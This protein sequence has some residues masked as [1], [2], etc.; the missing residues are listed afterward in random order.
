MMNDKAKILIVDDEPFN[1][2]Y[3]EQELEELG[4]ETVSA[5]D[6]QEALEQTVAENPDAILLDILMPELD[7]FQVLERLKA[8]EKW[9]NIPVIVISALGD[10]KSV[11]KGIEMGAEEYLPKPFDPVLLK[12]RISACL[13]KKRLH[14][15]ELG[16]L[17]QLEC[18]VQARTADLRVAYERLQ[19]LE[20]NKTDFIQV[21]AHELRTPL[22]VLRGCSEMLLVDRVIEASAH[23]HQLVTGI[24]S[25]AMRM[26]DVVDVMVDMARI[27]NRTLEFYPGLFI[28][29][30]L[31]ENVTHSFKGAMAD[32]KQTLAVEGIADLPEIE[33]DVEALKKLLYHLIVNAIKYTPDGGT[34]TISGRH[35]GPDV[36]ERETIEIVVGDTGIGID[37]Q[38]HELIFEK[39]Y[40]TE[41]VALHSS[42]KT[43]FKA[44]GPG[45][46]LS[47]VRGIVRAHGGKIWVESPGHDEETCPGS[48]FH[49][50]LPLQQPDPDIG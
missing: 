34:I 18:E 41:R 25:G 36:D 1:V 50:L 33:A 9:R 48:E 12:A 4:Y 16:Y 46:G 31:I 37:P 35:P 10:I 22:T 13:E 38:F 14:D 43:K 47:I 8:N 20:R 24:H 49:V 42:G 32:R 7:G 40:Q 26:Q 3:L 44:G 6:G 27:D 19:R 39:F 5:A 29:E 30:D 23:H 2:D 17:E 28:V 45:L 21:A 15:L 11:V